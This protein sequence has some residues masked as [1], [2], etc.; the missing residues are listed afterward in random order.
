M[1]FINESNNRC[2]LAN[3]HVEFRKKIIIFVERTAG[4]TMFQ[5][6]MQ[7]FVGKCR[8][9]PRISSPL[10]SSIS[11]SRCA[12]KLQVFTKHHVR[13]DPEVWSTLTSLC[14]LE[15]SMR[16]L[17]E[18]VNAIHCITPYAFD[19]VHALELYR[20]RRIKILGDW[21]DHLRFSTF[22]GA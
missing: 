14:L 4:V 2:L 16:E 18:G 10:A 3:T 8:R 20:Q 9:E 1:I 15:S 11:S 22:A 6:V 13:I 21:V 5:K 12:R 7:K 17:S 19:L